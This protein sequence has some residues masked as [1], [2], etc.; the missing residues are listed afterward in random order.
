MKAKTTKMTANITKSWNGV[1]VRIAVCSWERRTSASRREL[2]MKENLETLGV[3]FQL[4]IS[5]PLAY[6][7]ESIKDKADNV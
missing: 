1:K 5:C 6:L 3:N 2:R 4:S 7:A